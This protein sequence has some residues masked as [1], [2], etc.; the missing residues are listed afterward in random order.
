MTT[1]N[2][3]AFDVLAVSGEG[4]NARFI[5]IGTAW[6]AKTGPGF[7]LVLEALPMNSAVLMRPRK[8][9]PKP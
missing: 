4:D 3:P 1:T 5:R 6:P 2:K 7:N 8:S 9:A